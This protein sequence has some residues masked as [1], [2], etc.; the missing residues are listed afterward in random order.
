MTVTITQPC[1]TQ[2]YDMKTFLQFL[3]FRWLLEH[4][5]S[6]DDVQITNKTDDMACISIAGPLSRDLLSKVTSEDVSSKSFRF[7]KC[8]E[9]DV[10]GV[11][12]LALRVSYTGKICFLSRFLH[13]CTF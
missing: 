7:M 12:V 13:K 8:R 10:A 4:A 6:F 5:R 9:M 2:F 11:P 3:L 1:S